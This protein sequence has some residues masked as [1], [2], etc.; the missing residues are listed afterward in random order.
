MLD[1]FTHVHAWDILNPFW[2]L[3]VWLIDSEG[4]S[5][6]NC[7]QW[8]HFHF[9]TVPNS[10]EYCYNTPTH[11]SLTLQWGSLVKSPSSVLKTHRLVI[12]H[13]TWLDQNIIANIHNNLWFVWFSGVLAILTELNF[14]FWLFFIHVR[15]LLSKIMLGHNIWERVFR[16]PPLS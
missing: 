4:S 8:H 9:H 13:M 14:K 15:T 16:K 6:I 7:F 1:L 12:L 10:G 5:C 2:E 11:T 3:S